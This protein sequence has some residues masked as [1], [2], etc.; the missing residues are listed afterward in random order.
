MQSKSFFLLLLSL[1]LCHAGTT[2]V[3]CSSRGS[4]NLTRS[5]SAGDP[6]FVPC[7]IDLVINWCKKTE[8]RSKQTIFYLQVLRNLYTVVL[9]P[10]LGHKMLSSL[11]KQ[12]IKKC[13]S[14]E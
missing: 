4:C 10:I 14:S 9:P 8:D 11:R 2:T 3:V 6:G 1:S 12:K 7:G 13:T 5:S